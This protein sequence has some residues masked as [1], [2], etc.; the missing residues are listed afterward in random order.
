MTA[1]G[2]MVRNSVGLVFTLFIVRLLDS[3]STVLL[4]GERLSTKIADALGGSA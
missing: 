2:D 1:F 3:L 4:S